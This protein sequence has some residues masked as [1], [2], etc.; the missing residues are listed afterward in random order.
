[1]CSVVFVVVMLVLVLERLVDMLVLVALRDM[2]PH[3]SQHE[4]ATSR[5][6]DGEWLAE[7]QHGGQ[8]AG[9]RCNGKVGSGACRAKS[10]SART[11][12][13]KLRPYP[14]SPTRRAPTATVSGGKL[15]AG[16]GVDRDAHRAGHPALEPCD[17]DRIPT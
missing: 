4:R 13:T 10:R 15:R 1:M 16:H 6:L 12:S 11:N 7:R 3:A 14:N 17:Q 9:E 5:E 2:E 8:C